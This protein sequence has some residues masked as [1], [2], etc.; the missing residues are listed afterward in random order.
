MRRSARYLS[1]VERITILLLNVC[2]VWL[3]SYFLFG[4]RYPDGSLASM[5]LI[6]SIA[7][8]MLA[9]VSAPFFQPPKETLANGVG[10]LLSIFALTSVVS[11]P[12]VPIV[13][14]L[15]LVGAVCVASIALLLSLASI[16]VLGRQY[17]EVGKAIA[18]AS[19]MA[20]RPEMLFSPIVVAVAFGMPATSVL[21]AVAVLSIWVILVAAKPIEAVWAGVKGLS[22][23]GGGP[24]DVV[25]SVI[26]T[27]H[28]NIVR[29]R[30]VHAQTWTRECVHVARLSEDEL[31]FLLPLS[32]HYLQ[33]CSLGTG[34][35]IRS[36]SDSALSVSLG[37]VSVWRGDER[38]SEDVLQGA[39]GDAVRGEL[40]AWVVENSRIGRVR[41][42]MLDD[43]QVSAGTLV[44]VPVDA[45][46]VLYQVTDIVT[47][48]EDV[49]G[50]PFGSR[51]AEL[52]QIGVE[53]ERGFKASGSAPFMNA[54]VFR[55]ERKREVATHEPNDNRFA[56]GFLS[57]SQ[58]PF[59]V[60]LDD[61]VDHHSAVLGVTGT[62][63]TE[64]AFSVVREAIKRDVKV[65]CI[66]FTK[67]YG[68]RLA[69]LDPVHL[70]FRGEDFQELRGAID[71]VLFGDFAAAAERK[72]LVD[73]I[74]NQT[75]KIESQVR[76]FLE[77]DSA[78]LGLF[79]LEE[80]ANT[81][82]TLY[83]TELYLS[84]LFEWARA[85]RKRR[86]ILV[87]LEE[88]HTVVPESSLWGYQDRTDTAAVVGRIS[89][90]ALQGRK[91]GVGLLVVSQRTALVSKTVLT[92]CNTIFAMRMYDQTSLRFLESMLDQGHIDIIPN[93][94]FLQGV[95]W[96]KAIESDHALVFRIPFDG[97]KQTASEALDRVEGGSSDATSRVVE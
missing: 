53:Q 24:L 40:V 28:P 52:Q 2:C 64:L 97:S 79:S 70:G 6:I 95:A 94:Q 90:I 1:Q 22:S 86:R 21:D 30:L 14:E 23:V 32:R 93:L 63:K 35:A 73:L 4:V 55:V 54:P 60:N 8:W 17:D 67:E 61:L 10:A 50:T 34:L 96:G 58:F 72:N 44:C 51:T 46:V 12:I 49:A 37:D 92:Q 19:A 13:Y 68:P 29:V 7:Y 71:A 69:D 75:P 3:S 5:L 39:Y 62:G 85:N 89:Q 25:G 84:A 43:C 82:A 66:D 59:C 45:E 11:D 36:D 88:A 41:A 9:L 18:R 78:S 33:D 42:Q 31:V 81:R 56:V 38:D 16:A 83:A 77:G 57:D 48:E 65:V 27:D 15:A 47:R 20:G 91:Y 76:E 87:V 74:K 26:R 80:I